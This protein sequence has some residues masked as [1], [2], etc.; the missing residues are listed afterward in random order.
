[1][2]I[3]KL[4]NHF[5]FDDALAF[6][7]LFLLLIVVD[8]NPKARYTSGMFHKTDCINRFSIEERER[9]YSFEL[10]PTW[11]RW[12]TS[13]D[14]KSRVLGMELVDWPSPLPPA[15]YKSRSTVPRRS[16]LDNPSTRT[17]ASLSPLRVSCKA[18]TAASIKYVDVR[19][20]FFLFVFLGLDSRV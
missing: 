6:A 10:T 12:S 4:R 5:H 2:L 14:Q 3:N 7:V 19:L 15:A 11:Y 8:I 13:S 9:C 16:V 20:F 18:H 17:V 1:M